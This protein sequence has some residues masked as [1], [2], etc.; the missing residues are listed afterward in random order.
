MNKIQT[1]EL[2]LRTFRLGVISLVPLIG[3]PFGVLALH[4]SRRCRAT[5]LGE[6]NP[7]AGYLAWGI[8]LAC[9]GIVVSSLCFLVTLAAQF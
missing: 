7:A 8:R 2:S 9:F 6:W 4:A 3:L 1:I 5:A